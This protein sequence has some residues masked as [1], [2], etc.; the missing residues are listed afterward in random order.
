MNA[1]Y[2]K[3]ESKNKNFTHENNTVALL[4]NDIEGK[5][6]T[7]EYYNL[8]T[9]NGS[10]SSS[11]S[12]NWVIDNILSYDPIGGVKTVSYEVV[13]DKVTSDHMP[14]VGELLVGFEDPDA[15]GAV[16]GDDNA[17]AK[18]KVYTINGTA[19]A[20]TEDAITK[21]PDGIYIFDG[22]KLKKQ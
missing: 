8:A 22:K 14:I 7:P 21:L 16:K 9:A 2:T 18:S 19:V 11:L 5:G 20:S 4:S 10:I 1:S 12:E 15:V 13:D 3:V 17:A 6:Q